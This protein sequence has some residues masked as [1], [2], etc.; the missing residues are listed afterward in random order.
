MRNSKKIILAFV[1]VLAIAFLTNFFFV[2]KFSTD[3][4]TGR[5]TASFGERNSTSQIKWEQKLAEEISRNANESRAVQVA[6]KPNWQDLLIYEYL[7]GEY[8]LSVQ[9]GQIEKLRVQENREG[10]RFNTKD[11]VEKYGH[12]IKNFSS[13]K[14]LTVDGATERIELQDQAGQSAGHMLIER[15]DQGRVQSVVFQ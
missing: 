4:T 15:N 6:Q 11:F 3:S 8:D 14:I 13:Y 9:Q 5:Q 1:A 12:K 7:G 10:V 2:Q